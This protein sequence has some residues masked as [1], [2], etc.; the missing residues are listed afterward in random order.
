MNLSL[1][2]LAGRA[3]RC[4]AASASQARSAAFAVRSK[5]FSADGGPP[6]GSVDHGYE[7]ADQATYL[8]KGGVEERI[9]EVF[10]LWFV[11]VCVCV[12][13]TGTWR[14]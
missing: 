3:L 14:S 2:A 13:L 4:G 10:C 6:A 11:C 1:V 5:A 12:C 9:V 7:P 8:E